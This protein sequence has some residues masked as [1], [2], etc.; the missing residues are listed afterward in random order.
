MRSCLSVD[1]RED[2][3]SE[4][5]GVTGQDGGIRSKLS[6]FLFIKCKHKSVIELYITRVRCN[7]VCI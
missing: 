5:G 7:E 3:S 4:F 1:F 2:V 6:V